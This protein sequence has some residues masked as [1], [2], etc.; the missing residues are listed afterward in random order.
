MQLGGRKG[1]RPVK[2]WGGCGVAIGSVGVAPN[3]TVG[4]S[5]PIFFLCSTKPRRFS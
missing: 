1:I 4:A 2:T 3:W 5:A